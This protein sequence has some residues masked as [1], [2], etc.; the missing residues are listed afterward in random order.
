L[1][2]RTEDPTMADEM[3]SLRT[4]LEK[5]ADADRCARW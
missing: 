3:M 2:N 1:F 5:I 4:L